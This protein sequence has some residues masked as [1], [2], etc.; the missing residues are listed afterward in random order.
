MAKEIVIWCEC[1]LAQD[2]NRVVGHEHEV[3]LNGKTYTIDLCDD[4]YAQHLAP[5][6]AVLVEFGQP[7]TRKY[8]K[9]AAKSST[10]TI[11]S[12]DANAEGEFVCNEPGC[13]RSFNRPQG[14]G[15]HML[16]HKT[17]VALEPVNA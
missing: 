3:T 7:V 12:D 4:C 8:T 5:L 11:T 6:E 1:D 2:E 17:K 14:L 10:P 13:G 16:S 9:K 15:R